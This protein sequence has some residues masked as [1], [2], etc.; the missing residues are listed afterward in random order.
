MSSDDVNGST[1]AAVPDAPRLTLRMSFLV[2]SEDIAAA[3]AVDIGALPTLSEMT[4]SAARALS[5]CLPALP[6]EL[7][8]AGCRPRCRAAAICGACDGAG[9]AVERIGPLL[10][11]SSAL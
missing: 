9:Q 8:S 2:Q 7:C 10:T 5:V 11:G 6:R 1:A 3:L 4:E